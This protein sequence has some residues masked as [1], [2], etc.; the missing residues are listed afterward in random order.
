MCTILVVVVFAALAIRVT[1]LQVLSGDHY[2][3]MALRQRLRT[4]PLNAERGSIF[5]RNG[6]DL[7]ISIERNSVYADPRS[8]PTRRSSPRS[9]RRSSVSISKRCTSASPTSRTDSSTSPAPSTTRRSRR[10]AISVSPV[11]RSSPSR[12]ASTRPGS[13]ASTIIGRVGGEGF[14][15]DG[16]EAYYDDD[17]KGTPG[18][19]VVERDQRGRDIPDTERKRIAARSGTDIVLSIDQALQYQVEQSLADQ[20][21][22]TAAKGGMAVIVDVQTGDVLAMATCRARA[23]ANRPT[24]RG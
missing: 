23:A 12:N 19:V 6:R 13:V 1:Q 8:S 7:A 20:V 10:C 15:L 21:T 4:I 2:E 11:W 3:A 17:L 22:A 24:P 9:S 16:L 5:D 14:G 18:E